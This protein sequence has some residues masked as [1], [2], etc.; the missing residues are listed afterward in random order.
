MGGVFRQETVAVRCGGARK[1]PM[2]GQRESPKAVLDTNVFVAAGFNPNSSSAELLK[3]VAEGN[4]ELVWTGATKRETRFVLES[5]PRLSW[6]EIEP[7]FRAQ[8]EVPDELPLA[9]FDY[10]VDPDDRKFAALAAA[11]GATLVSSDN[12]LLDHRAR[13]DIS[14]ASP[15]QFVRQIRADEASSR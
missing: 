7:L 3:L 8:A 2:T 12:H 4:V 10:I 5:I 6:D 13:E 9:D 15:S 14:I 1:W 11:S